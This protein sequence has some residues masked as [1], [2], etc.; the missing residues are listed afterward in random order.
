MIDT[1]G[2]RKS[3]KIYE[4]TEKYSVMRAMRAIDR[5][6]VV[7]MVLMPKKG[8]GSTT[9]GSLALLMKLVKV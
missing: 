9:S 7:L 6:D 4:N 2:M 8:F 5:S 1:A 3:G